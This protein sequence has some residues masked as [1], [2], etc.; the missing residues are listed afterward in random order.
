MAGLNY[1]IISI[2]TQNYLFKSPNRYGTKWSSRY[3]YSSSSFE[4]CSKDYN[5]K[6]IAP[7][8]MTKWTS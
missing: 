5:Y 7:G 3:S 8:S 4:K 6:V 1:G 2:R